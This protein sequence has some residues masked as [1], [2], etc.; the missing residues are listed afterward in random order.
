M[1]H[2]QSMKV[3]ED[4]IQRALNLCALYKHI[5]ESTTDALEVDDLLRSAITLSVSAF[6]YLIHEIIRLEC[7]Y[8]H[9][10]GLKTQRIEIPISLLS[11]T[12]PE[13][14]K[15]LDAHIKNINGYKSFISP[16]KVADGLKCFL[17]SP[18]TEITAIDG[19]DES[20]TK[21]SLKLIADWRNRIA[22]E[23]DI[24]P[25][26]GGT[27]L[28]PIYHSDVIESVE[29][30]RHLGGEICEAIKNSRAYL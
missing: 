3:Y 18:W 29:F 16:K 19:R 17:Q 20:E 22:H 13:R 5:N 7:L 27:Q 14:T 2:S 26:L 11:T 6:D 21:K 30:L 23:A 4:C 9:T 1:D 15:K 25:D 12:E 8:R 10:N 24:N 28:W